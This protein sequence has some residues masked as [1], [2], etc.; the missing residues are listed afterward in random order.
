MALTSAHARRMEARFMVLPPLEMSWGRRSTPC[1]VDAAPGITFPRALQKRRSRPPHCRSRLADPRV[2]A[3]RWLPGAPRG[4]NTATVASDC[5]GSNEKQRVGAAGFEPAI[6]RTQIERDTRLRHAPRRHRSLLPLLAQSVHP[7]PEP[8]S[9]PCLA[10]RH[11]DH[12]VAGA[13]DATR[14]L[15]AVGLALQPDGRRVGGERLGPELAQLAEILVGVILD[16]ERSS[17]IVS[18]R[19]IRNERAFSHR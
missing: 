5:R 12:A 13:P 11:R 4:A 14:Q 19:S 18:L 2:G 17:S 6:S 16:V 7:G 1:R 8:R 3:S 10:H 15:L 9:Q